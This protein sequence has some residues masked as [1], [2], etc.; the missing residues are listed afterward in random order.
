MPDKPDKTFVGAYVDTT[1]K[2]DHDAALKILSKHEKRNVTTTE[3]IIDA[4]K[5]NIQKA[6]RI[7]DDDQK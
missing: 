2:E 5:R 7:E 6:E 1:L 4:Y 3:T